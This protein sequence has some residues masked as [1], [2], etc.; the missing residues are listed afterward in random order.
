[1]GE[2]G[3]GQ[4]RC[5]GGSG[6]A[7]GAAGWASTR[8]GMQGQRRGVRLRVC[9]RMQWC[10]RARE[11]LRSAVVGQRVDEGACGNGGRGAA[12]GRRRSGARSVRGSSKSWPR[13]ATTVVA[14]V[15]ARGGE[16]SGGNTVAQSIMSL[17]YFFFPSSVD[18]LNLETGLVYGEAHVLLESDNDENVIMTI[19]G[20]SKTKHGNLHGFGAEQVILVHDDASKKQII[21]HVGKQALVLT[22]VECKG[23]EFQDVLLYNFFGS[24]PLRNKWRVL[25]GY[26]KDKD[27]ISHSKEI[28]HPSFDRS[29]HYLLCSDLK[30]LYVAITRTRQRLWICENTEDYYRPMFDYWKK[31][32]L[33]EVRLLDSS[34][35]QAMQTGSSSDDWMLWGTKVGDLTYLVW[36]ANFNLPCYALC[37]LLSN[38]CVFLVL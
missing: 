3:E 19:F 12:Q 11:R 9:V 8:S 14:G 33:V 1:M 27:I 38:F 37:C 26:M 28:S 5:G 32:C 30:Q 35:I 24:S 31:L 29:K 21:D 10:S 2:R 15:H 22:I 34:L 18:K 13:R 6:A 16:A 36:K 17:L 23:L 25:Y 4:G 20:E 7:G